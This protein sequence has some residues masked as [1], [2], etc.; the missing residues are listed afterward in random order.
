[1]EIMS[2]P[3]GSIITS[4]R[5]RS[6]TNSSS[7]SPRRAMPC[8]PSSS[9]VGS[10]QEVFTNSVA[11]S[12]RVDPPAPSPPNCSRD[13][14][15]PQPLVKIIATL[16]LKEAVKVTVDKCEDLE[17]KLNLYTPDDIYEDYDEVSLHIHSDGDRLRYNHEVLAEFRKMLGGIREACC[18]A[19]ESIKALLLDYGDSMP[20]RQKEY[21]T[22][23]ATEIPHL[24]KS[25]KN[26]LRAAIRS[27]GHL[28]L[29]SAS[30]S[31]ESDESKE[32][33][34]LT[35]LK[36]NDA[37]KLQDKTCGKNWI[38]TEEHDDPKLLHDDHETIDDKA[39]VTMK[40]VKVQRK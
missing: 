18:G 35:E 16:D 30:N 5:S 40:I 9:K 6:P 8:S 15:K 19:E 39:T 11:F 33:Q 2:K 12:P 21:W 26:Q 32:K 14:I 7:L 4:V 34:V 23:Q 37:G 22:K 28:V 10:K 31:S 20:S 27:V 13:A 38:K 36:S 17:S 25:H 3:I 1:M 24:A 29:A